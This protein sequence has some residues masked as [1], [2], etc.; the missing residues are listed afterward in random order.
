MVLPVV[1]IELKFHVK[2]QMRQRILQIKTRMQKPFIDVYRQLYLCNQRSFDEQS[3]NNY[4]R[5]D[6]FM[7]WKTKDDNYE[8]T[9][10][11]QFDTFF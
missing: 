11:A 2:K 6:R 10:Y 5:K 9:Q 4:I 7:E 3:R 1:L 8:N